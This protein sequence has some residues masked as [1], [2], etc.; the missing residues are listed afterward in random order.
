MAHRGLGQAVFLFSGHSALDCVAWA[1]IVSP[2]ILLSLAV[3]GVAFMLARRLGWG[4]AGL[5]V[6]VLFT[7]RTIHEGFVYGMVD[8]HGIVFSFAIASVLALV[9]SGAGLVN[10]KKRIF[11]F[12]WMRL[13]L[14]IG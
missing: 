7:S 8:H 6:L 3:A 11:R 14:V 9:F 5:F 12:F 2:L 1:A 4:I 13:P 10:S